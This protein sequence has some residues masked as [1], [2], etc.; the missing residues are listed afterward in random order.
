[1]PRKK[2]GNAPGR[3]SSFQGEKLAWLETYEEE[4]RIIARG[5]FYDD[6][7]KRFLRR[8]GYDLPVEDNAPGDVEDWVPV[9]RKAG[10]TG[11]ELRA[12]NDFQDEA[13]KKLRTKLSNWYRHRFLGKK[14]HRGALRSILKRMQSLGGGSMRPRRKSNLAYY[15]GKY[16]ATRMKDG[17]DAEWEKAKTTLDTNMRVSM[18]QDY[19]NTKWEAETKEF[20]DKMIVRVERT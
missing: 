12:E 14:V 13:F 8:Y 19:V 5:K 20:K 11:D 4:F 2:N 1:M 6:I 3:S 16:Y 7:T 17:F 18:C 10:L 15:S 9:N